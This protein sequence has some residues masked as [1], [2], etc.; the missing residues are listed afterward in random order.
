MPMLDSQV[1]T[2]GKYKGTR[3]SS[4]PSDYLKWILDTFDHAGNPAIIDYIRRN[5]DRLKE[6][7]E[8][9]KSPGSDEG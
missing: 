5:Q 1:M 8:K 2:F 4:V 9:D 3:L 6:E 7:Y